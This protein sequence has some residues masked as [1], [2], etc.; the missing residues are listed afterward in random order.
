VVIQ[1]VFAVD[2]F[3]VQL[4]RALGG[5]GA[6]LLIIAF[7]GVTGDI[8]FS[9]AFVAVFTTA[10]AGDG[11]M[12]QRLPGMIRFVVFGMLVGGLAF[13]STDNAAEAAIVLGIVTYLTTLGAAYG[14]AT[15]RRGMYLTLWALFSLLLGS[16]DTSALAAGLAFLVGGAIAIATTALRLALQ[17]NGSADDPAPTSGIRLTDVVRGR[18][19]V[20]SGFRAAAVSIAVLLGFWWF[21]A[22]PLWVA[23]TVIVIIRPSAGQTFEVA[24]QRTLGT[25]IGAAIAV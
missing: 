9:V 10:A 3:Q 24:V 25:A 7:I 8:A 1:R 17:G 13:L 11:S 23:I 15:A 14:P 19:G 6:V 22:Y 16:A 20:L 2:W 18:L 21:P 4:K 5:L 12:R